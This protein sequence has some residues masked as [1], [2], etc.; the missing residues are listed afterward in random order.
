MILSSATDNKVFTE[1]KT[2][3]YALPEQF[4]NSFLYAQY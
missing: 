3:K 4:K 1:S 2:D